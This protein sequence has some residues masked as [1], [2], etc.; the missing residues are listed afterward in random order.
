MSVRVR[1][2]VCVYVCVCVRTR[3]HTC[4]H[5]LTYAP[6]C[7]QMLSQGIYCCSNEALHSCT[8]FVSI[9]AKMF[10]EKL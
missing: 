7:I 9:P 10:K 5:A 8:M 2:R 6:S 3:V 1:V 4:M